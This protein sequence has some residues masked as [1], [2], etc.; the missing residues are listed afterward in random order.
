MKKT[1]LYISICIILIGCNRLAER[2]II[3]NQ[4]PENLHTLSEIRPDTVIIVSKSFGLNNIKCYWRHEI[5]TDDELIIKLL[6]HNTNKILLEHFNFIYVDPNYNA[7]DYFDQ[8]N[9]DRFADVNFDGFTD[10]L[11]KFQGDG[12]I[13]DA[14]D[15]FLFNKENKIYSHS[16]DLSDNR[17]GKID[18][19][20]KKLITTNSSRHGSDSTIH[21]FNN[22]GKVIAR[23]TFSSYNTSE[24]TIW[25]E[26]KT[27]QKIVNGKV[28][29]ENHTID[30]IR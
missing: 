5:T 21:Y 2:N 6:E 12:P 13:N 14:I 22:T 8:I 17:I 1:I 16:R 27:Y 15:I 29:I 25:L 26:H 11:I 3:M 18:A 9:K 20:N 23:E 7:H 19:K 4:N 30:T 10:I 24:D 28:T